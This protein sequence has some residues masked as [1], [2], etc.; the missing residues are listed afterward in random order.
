MPRFPEL[1]GEMMREDLKA[2]E[3]DALCP[4]PGLQDPAAARVLAGHAACLPELPSP[5]RKVVTTRYGMPVD[6]LLDTTT[7]PGSPPMYEHSTPDGL[8]LLAVAALV[9]GTIG[10]D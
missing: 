1:V 2:A 8:P 5:P 3:R 6:D 9:R 7:Q 10:H 4:P